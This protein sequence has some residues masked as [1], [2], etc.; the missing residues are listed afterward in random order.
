MN[1]YAPFVCFVSIHADMMCANV[2]LC[3]SLRVRTPI[4]FSPSSVDMTSLAIA[5][6][7]TYGSD[8]KVCVCVRDSVCVFV[9]VCAYRS[10]LG[11]C[12]VNGHVVNGCPA[13][14]TCVIYLLT[15]AA[16]PLCR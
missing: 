11:V 8:H 6:P 16:G 15:R 13:L 1:V 9:S 7:P 4:V 10:E 14:P 3:M 12:V 5:L 2:S